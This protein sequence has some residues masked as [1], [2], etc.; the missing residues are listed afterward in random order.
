MH[1]ASGLGEAAV[2]FQPH[3]KGVTAQIRLTPGARRTGFLGTMPIADDRTALKAG[4][5]APPE[6][7]KANKELLK[8]MAREW[9]LPK[10]S[11]QII[12]GETSRQK[13]ILIETGDG[14]GLLARLKGWLQAQED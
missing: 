4:V 12:A 6:D 14:A 3:A 7:G 5:S 10:S 2:P 8:M 9:K 1:K 13:T 11:L